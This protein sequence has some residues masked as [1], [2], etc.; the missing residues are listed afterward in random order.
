MTGIAMEIRQH[1]GIVAQRRP[2]PGHKLKLIARGHRDHSHVGHAIIP[3]RGTG[4]IRVIDE[5]PLA[6]RQQRDGQQID[7]GN[8]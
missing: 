2:P 1:R 7:D 3:R 6:P 4:R 8:A 5:T